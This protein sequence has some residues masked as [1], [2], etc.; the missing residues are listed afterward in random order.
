MAGK[1]E[2]ES[3]MLPSPDRSP[4]LFT[5]APTQLDHKPGSPV[6]VG[7]RGWEIDPIVNDT[8]YEAESR[9]VPKDISRMGVSV[10]PTSR[11]PHEPHAH[12][13][14]NAAKAKAQTPTTPKSESRDLTY[15]NQMG[16]R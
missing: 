8:K 2:Y 13:Y 5:S 12:F 1:D 16:I 7:R 10:L 9:H 15:Q 4:G 14:E 6:G 3:I 11:A